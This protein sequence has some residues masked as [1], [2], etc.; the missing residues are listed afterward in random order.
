M[1]FWKA[2]FSFRGRI[3]RGDFWISVL[4][5]VALWC[6]TALVSFIPI[7]GVQALL[8]AIFLLG[9]LIVWFA[10]A[11]RRLHDRD[12]SAWYLFLFIGLPSALQMA[13]MAHKPGYTTLYLFSGGTGSFVDLVCLA[14]SIWMI[15]ELGFLRGTAGP[16]Q[17]GPD[18]SAGSEIHAA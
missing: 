14:I 10:A 11:T 12:K 8:V 18:P 17:Y 7:A 3:N 4:W 5:V 6:A 2:L 9:G 16:N 13:F 15:V 1:S